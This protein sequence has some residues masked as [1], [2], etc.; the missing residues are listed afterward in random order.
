VKRT[1]SQEMRRNLWGGISLTCELEWVIP[2]PYRE[3]AQQ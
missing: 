1:G 2:N 3:S